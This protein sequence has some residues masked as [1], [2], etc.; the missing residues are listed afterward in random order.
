MIELYAMHSEVLSEKNKYDTFLL[1]ASN[2]LIDAKHTKWYRQFVQESKS[3]INYVLWSLNV[4][5][6]LLR[7]HFMGSRDLNLP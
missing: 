2:S 4:D 3:T 7:S 6:L 5:L 1:E